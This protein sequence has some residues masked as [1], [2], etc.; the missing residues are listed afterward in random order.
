MPV[1]TFLV[2]IACIGPP[3][4]DLRLSVY[5]GEGGDC[6]GWVGPVCPLG[7]RLDKLGKLIGGMSTPALL[8]EEVRVFANIEVS[9]L[10]REGHSSI[11]I[12]KS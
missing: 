1:I 8:G 9:S 10:S 12:L 5:N 6:E 7:E 4:K 11:L 3:L 2:F